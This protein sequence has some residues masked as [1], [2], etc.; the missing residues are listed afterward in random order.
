MT[1]QHDDHPSADE[2]ADGTAPVTPDQTGTEAAVA[3]GRQ[4]GRTMGRR[5]FVVGGGVVGLGALGLYGLVRRRGGSTD[6]A[7]PA[8][9]PTTAPPGDQAAG[10]SPPGGGDGAGGTDRPTAP[11][12][13]LSGAEPWSSRY[14]TD[15]GDV[16]ID[17]DIVLD[18]D[19]RVASLTIDEG[20]RLVLDPAASV[21]LVS[22]GNVV[23][24][25]VLEMRPASAEQVHTVRFEGVDES[26]YTGG[27]MAVEATDI[28]LWIVQTGVLAATGAAKSPW[29]RASGDLAAGATVVTVE[30]ATGW[31]VGDRVAITPTIAPTVDTGGFHQDGENALAYDEALITSVD[32]TSVG[33]DRALEHDHPAI[34]FTRWDGAEASYGA[35]VLNL[36]RNVVVAGTETGRAHVLFLACDKRQDLTSVQFDQLG[37]RQSVGQSRNGKGDRT[38]GVVGRYPFHMHHCGRGVEGS[39]IKDCVVTSSGNR[40]FVPHESH[41]VTLERC[42]AHDVHGTAFWWDQP[43][44]HNPTGEKP[45]THDSLWT[46]CVASKV[47]ADQLSEDA[48]RLAGFNLSDGEHGSNTLVDSVAVG[49][50]GPRVTNNT[51]ARSGFHWTEHGQAVWNFQNCLAHNIAGNGILTWQ[52][53]ELVHTIE[54]FTA[55]HC[56]SHGIE[57]GA[58]SNFYHYLGLTLVA[59]RLSG[60]GCHAVTR[61]TN[62]VRRAFTDKGVEAPVITFRDVRVDGRGITVDGVRGLSHRFAAEQPDGPTILENFEVT[63]CTRAG[64]FEGDGKRPAYYVMRNWQVDDIQPV[65]LDS[66]APPG[67]RIDVED[68]NG[69][70]DSYTITA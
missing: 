68:L 47:W 19:A 63:G 39:V 40:A 9:A 3:A 5:G 31:R 15:E 22:S 32:G 6:V 10:T 34:S 14:A 65:M 29:T 11:T 36:T 24:N 61:R 37:P 50:A 38:S 7:D 51:A 64:L 54:D 20:A 30:D 41:G 17:G 62:S 42:V 59:N 45:K 60:I 33:L 49:V 12:S 35:E 55:Y 18:T 23:V 2:P 13:D 67:T 1:N 8:G 43:G 21:T 27:G 57:H 26:A 56:A 58:Y 48:Y 66:T 44:R 52:N 25:G 4:P 46:G 53:D 70:T 16:V 28:G 69:S